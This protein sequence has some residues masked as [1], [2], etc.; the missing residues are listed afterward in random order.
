M[1]TKQRGKLVCHIGPFSTSMKSTGSSSIDLHDAANS[2][3][4]PSGIGKL[5]Q[6]MEQ[7]M[8]HFRFSR[9][10][11]RCLQ[12]QH[13]QLHLLIPQMVPRQRGAN[14]ELGCRGLF[15]TLEIMTIV[16]NS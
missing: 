8:T 4:H 5:I 13:N 7:A 6:N 1:E 14:H 15:Q 2:G 12:M 11:D 10:G 9:A 3:R 16:R